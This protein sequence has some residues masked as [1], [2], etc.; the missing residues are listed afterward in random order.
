M[1]AAGGVQP[2]T[3]F[4]LD[5]LGGDGLAEDMAG[6]LLAAQVEE[7]LDAS[8][9]DRHAQRLEREEIG[10]HR[11]R[12]PHSAQR[13]ARVPQPMGCKRHRPRDVMARAK[14]RHYNNS[15]KG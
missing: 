15:G 11:Q 13:D 14:S 5:A 3:K 7:L 1:I 4:T 9:H 12:E 2:G 6:Q 8:V 10:A